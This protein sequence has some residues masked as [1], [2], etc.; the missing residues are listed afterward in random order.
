MKE[1]P[2]DQ[3]ELSVNLSEQNNNKNYAVR[4]IK[5]LLELVEAALA[6]KSILSTYEVEALKKEINE[7]QT[8]EADLSSIDN[9]DERIRVL[10]QKVALVQI[11]GFL[12]KTIVFKG[13]KKNQMALANWYWVTLEKFNSLKDKIKP[14]AKDRIQKELD[15]IKGELKI[16]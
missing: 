12:E 6:E 1:K 9:L 15:E 8:K 5:G 3:K 14:D 10:E 2:I 7:A 11:E 4:K 13:D 16:E